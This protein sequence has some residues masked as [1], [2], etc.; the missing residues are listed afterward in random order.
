MSFWQL[1]LT[2]AFEFAKIGLF[3][4]GGGLATLPFLTDLSVKYGWYSQAQLANMIAIS[5]STPGPIGINMA[6]YA[7]YLALGIPGAF[8]ATIALVTPSIII[9]LLIAKF[10]ANFSENKMVKSAFAGL[11]PAVAAM[12]ASALVGL[13]QVTLVLPAFSISNIQLALFNW[14]AIFVFLV[15]LVLVH[16]KKFEKVHP[17]VWLAGS[18]VC[19]ILLQI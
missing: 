10:M 11:R 7:G 14:K 13:M 9:I 1:A 3:A 2:L 17:V 4:V 18:A 8:I 5:E 19:G 16:V 6:T 15:V 12:I